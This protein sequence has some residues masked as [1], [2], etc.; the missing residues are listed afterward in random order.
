MGRFSWQTVKLPKGIRRASYLSPTLSKHSQWSSKPDWRSP[1]SESWLL[2]GSTNVPA[3]QPTSH[4]KSNN[5]QV[6]DILSTI[7]NG[8]RIN[9]LA[10]S[11]TGA[12]PRNKR[13]SQPGSRSSG[14]TW[15]SH[16][17]LSW[18]TPVLRR[19]ALLAELWYILVSSYHWQH[20]FLGFHPWGPKSWWLIT[21]LIER[22][23]V[24]LFFGTHCTPCLENPACYNMFQPSLGLSVCHAWR[25]P[26]VG[27]VSHLT[28]SLA[29]QDPHLDVHGMSQQP[30]WHGMAKISAS[31][32]V[33]KVWHF[34]DLRIRD[35]CLFI[36][37]LGCYPYGF[38]WK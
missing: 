27:Y 38:V 18:K 36:R 9:N 33:P 32:M 35:R 12:R 24:L 13:S 20:G 25:I 28:C 16:S 26:S 8:M 14:I 19:E 37:P 7:V 31:Q 3:C 10:V 34:L 15:A 2:N 21:F 22:T 11:M 23:H 6:Y 5:C 30:A 17:D 4:D 29:M 1:F